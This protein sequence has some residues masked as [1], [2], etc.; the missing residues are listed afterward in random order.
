MYKTKSYIRDTQDFIKKIKDIGPIPD[1]ALLVTLDVTSLY[2]NIPNEDG[3]QSIFSRMREDPDPDIPSH[4]LIKLLEK[5]LTRNYF[6]FNGKLYL[7]IGGTAMGTPIAPSYAGTFMGKHE[8]NVLDIYPHKP[9]VWLRFLDDVFCL[10]THGR[11]ELDNFITYLNDSH[12]TIKFTS[13]INPDQI[14]FLDT[15]VKVDKTTRRVYT[16]VYSKPTDTH[17]YLHF[18]SSH[19]DHCKTGGPKGQ[20][21]RMRRIC[22][23]DAD[24]QYHS[25]LM[26]KQYIR[27]GYPAKIMAKHLKVV[28]K[29][30]QD[31][32][33]EV[34]VKPDP[35]LTSDR[36]ILTLEYNPANPDVLGIIRENWPLIEC[37][38]KLSALFPSQPMLAHKKSRNIKIS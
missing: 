9:L 6:E 31:D 24:F 23:K 38:S 12:E 36:I 37:S 4:F 1:N 11:E 20:L 22:T 17:D 34:K 25:Q 10:W 30:K 35:K 26:T 15:C 32:L 29:L 19:P 28:E 27:R 16:T 18:T 3:L 8:E 5:V 33:L 7:Q 2:T 14:N 21:L 13:E